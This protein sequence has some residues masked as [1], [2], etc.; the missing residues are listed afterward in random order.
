M[1][2][3]VDFLKT[4]A[5]R[6]YEHIA[7]VF[8]GTFATTLVFNAQHI[9]AEG[10]LSAVKSAVPSLVVA[11]VYAAWVKV[12]PLLPTTVVQTVEKIVEIEKQ[13]VVRKKS[14][15]PKKQG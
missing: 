13:A 7:I 15:A 1:T 10:G 9:L 8:L 12:R 3:V 5:G 4:P 14:T 11:G 6:T 2:K